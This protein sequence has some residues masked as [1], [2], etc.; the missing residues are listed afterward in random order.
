MVFRA[1]VFIF[2]FVKHLGLSTDCIFLQIF[3]S[4]TQSEESQTQ[5]EA[6]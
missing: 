2:L 6:I 5:S 1:A 4:Q 3:Q